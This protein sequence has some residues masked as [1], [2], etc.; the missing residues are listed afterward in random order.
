M[1]EIEISLKDTYLIISFIFLSIFCCIVFKMSLAY[2]FLSSIVFCSYIYKK[3]GL[4]ISK[5]LN[6]IKNTLIECKSLLILIIFIGAI[7]SVWLLSGIVPAMMYYGLK[8]MQKINFLLA[9]FIITSIVAIFMGTAI[10]TISTIGIALLGLGKAFGI[11]DYIIL[12]AIISGASIGDR[13]SPISSLFNLTLESIRIKYKD[14]LKS[15]LVTLIPGYFICSLIYYFIGKNYSI[16]NKSS[17]VNT[18][19]FAINKSFSISPLLLLI[20]LSIVVMSFIGVKILKSVSI[21]IILSIIAAVFVQKVSLASVILVM[22]TG[23]K[24]HTNFSSLNKILSSGGII[25]MFEILLIIIGALSLSSLLCK[26]KTIDPIV[27]K[28]TLKIKSKG[29]LIF[30]TGIM[31]GL[32]TSISDQTVGIII[33]CNFLKDKYK[34]VKVENNILARTISDTGIAVAPLIP[35]NANSLFIVAVTGI[36]VPV[37]IPYAI[38]CY[39]SPVITI[40]AAFLSKF[41]I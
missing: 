7:I 27:K 17:D 34:E 23:Y 20:P 9:A 4:S 33:P 41:G 15:V 21:G 18:L 8:Y 3:N 28:L 32:L 12:G 36:S 10:G 26:T 2:G 19:T 25:S 31:S 16:A 22:L 13:I 40:F 29:E 24:S 1:A 5:I 6:I 38:L 37:Y 39:V 35:W 30:K 14:A 11:P